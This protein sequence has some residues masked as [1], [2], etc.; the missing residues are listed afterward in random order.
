ME[1]IPRFD[2]EKLKNVQIR[3][4]FQI[5]LTNCFQILDMLEDQADQTMPRVNIEWKNASETV[6]E[7]A[8]EE[9]RY[10][11]KQGKNHWF[12]EEC[13]E[14]TKT[15]K[16]A[17]LATLQNPDNEELH[18]RLMLATHAEDW[19]FDSVRI[20]ICGLALRLGMKMK[21]HTRR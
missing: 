11:A 18:E 15:R 17:Y 7:I 19:H 8:E 16:M 9:I 2:I 10:V 5:K 1:K 14:A 20:I 12:D 21:P 13:E 3:N 4:N 6:K